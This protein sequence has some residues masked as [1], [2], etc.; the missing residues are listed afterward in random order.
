M[1]VLVMGSPLIARFFFDTCFR[2]VS[3]CSSFRV[4]LLILVQHGVDALTRGGVA[5][6][7]VI[8]WV[9]CWRVVSLVMGCYLFAS[10]RC[11]VVL[12]CR[13]RCFVVV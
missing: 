10:G 1:V 9:L 6:S 7:V 8:C 4:V 2:C 12:G 3:G 11:H 5:V 13:C